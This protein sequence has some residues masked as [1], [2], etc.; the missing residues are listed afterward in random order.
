MRTQ[1]LFT[2]AIAVAAS[3]ALTGCSSLQGNSPGMMP[4]IVLN[5]AWNSPDGMT[6]GADGN[7]YLSMNNKGNQE[8][9][10]MILRIRADD[11]IEKFSDLPVHPKTGKVSPLGNAIASD[12]NLYVAD[13]QMFV[14]SDKGVSR[15]LRVK[16]RNGK[17]DGVEVVV[18]GLNMANGVSAHGNYVAVNDTTI[19]DEAG[20]PLLSGTYR[21]TLDELKSG[22]PVKV[23]GWN[24]PHLVVKVSTKTPDTGRVGAN[25]L[26]YD[27]CGTLYTA[28]FGDREIVKTTFAA[29]GTPASTTI[30][31]TQ[32][33][34]SLDGI[35]WQNGK[36]Y[37][38]DFLGN[39][40]ATVDPDSGKTEILAKNAPG[41]GANGD[42]DAPSECLLR[43]NTLYVSNIDI[44]FGPN[45]GDPVHTISRLCVKADAAPKAAAKPQIVYDNAWFYN[46][47]GSFNAERG[48]DA[49]M[50]LAKYHGYPIF[51]SMRDS[52]WVSD[53]G[54][55]QYTKLGLA[56]IMFKNNEA[57]RYM[58]MD[59][60]LM[61]G[62]MLP[63][64]WH[65]ATDKNP[66]KREG[67]LVRFGLS[68]VVGEGEPNLPAGVVVPACH[69]NG[70]VSIKHDIVAGPGTFVP[71]GRVESHH[72]QMAGREGAIIS[73]TANVHDNSGVR[74]AD[75]KVNDFFLSGK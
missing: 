30:L 24:D 25:G 70:T 66:A 55:G 53:Y 2:T 22:T 35:H 43:G 10:A 72:W 26:S 46:A 57:D 19:V 6:L 1:T 51:P 28:N 59:L 65:L 36:I 45:T 71:L 17:A 14:T 13:N 64:H 42:F 27:D 48:K 69:N 58:A 23:T 47:D 32:G 49:I 18:E 20:K 7:I 73:E 5:E 37:V 31:K 50:A 60:F 40:V 3:A 44:S 38:A 41:D 39:A 29:N 4:P 34:Q 33:V 74:H 54:T 62:Q 75:Q 9:P 15:L 61:P 56:A 63:E 21:F 67:W 11:Q 12:G 8:L 16:I 68:H 52:I